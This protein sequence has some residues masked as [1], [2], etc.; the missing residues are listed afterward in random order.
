M[1]DKE[2]ITELDDVINDTIDKFVP[3]ASSKIKAS[4]VEIM[5]KVMVQG[6][7]PLEAAGLKP[8]DLEWLY[9]Q[10][11]NLYKAGQYKDS[12]LLFR[13]VIQINPMVSKYYIGLG[14]CYFMLKEYETAIF[15]YLAADYVDKAN[16]IPLYYVAEC[17]LKLNNKPAALKA[18]DQLLELF[19][20]V[21]LFPHLR[22]RIRLSAEQLRKEIAAEEKY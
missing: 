7:N 4:L 18:Y 1:A 5:N 2:Q 13:A 15:P 22:E 9:A 8:E 16:P 3:N 19:K 6:M 21:P 20:S 11:Y 12:I 14:A 10:A 17:F